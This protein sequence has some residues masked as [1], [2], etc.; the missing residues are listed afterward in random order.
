MS[1]FSRDNRPVS[2]VPPIGDGTAPIYEE[3]FENGAY[4]LK[5]TGTENLFDFVQA[6]KEETLVYNILSRYQRGD[7]TA[8]NQRVGQYLDVVGMPSNLAEAY[9]TM[10]N[11]ESKFNSLSPDI[12]AK[13]DNDV[14]VFVDV[15]S[16]S[17]PDKLQELFGVT[18]TQ[19]DDVKEGDLNVA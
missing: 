2:K 5:Q 11:V 17:T 18:Q 1:F 13:F 7:L 3:V 8:L 9:N 19:V 14:N 12:R 15:V 10:L 6:S 16:H 4:G